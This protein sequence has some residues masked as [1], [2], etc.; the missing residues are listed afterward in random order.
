LL[1]KVMSTAPALGA[2]LA[3]AQIVLCQGKKIVLQFER[4]FSRK[5][6]AQPENLSSV[7]SELSQLLGQP[8]DIECVLLEETSQELESEEAAISA[9]ET[10][11]LKV[12]LSL[13]EGQSVDPIR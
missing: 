7:C 9:A 8:V 1:A 3:G 11:A 5:V 2:K 12:A 6:V 13:F 10:D 4:E